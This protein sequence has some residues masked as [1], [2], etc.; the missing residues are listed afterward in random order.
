MLDVGQDIRRAEALQDL[1]RRGGH[2][3]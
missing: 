1:P 3:S 2:V